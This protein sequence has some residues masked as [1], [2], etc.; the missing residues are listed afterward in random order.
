MVQDDPVLRSHELHVDVEPVR[1]DRA[2]EFS[3]FMAEAQPV[4]WRMAWLLTGDVH[5]SEDLVQQA[6]VRTYV[7]WPRAR[8]TDP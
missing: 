8:A 1:R 5:R 7:A 6:L 2:T 4:L 3:E